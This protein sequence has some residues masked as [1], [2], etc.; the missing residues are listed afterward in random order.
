MIFDPSAALLQAHPS[1]NVGIQSFNAFDLGIQQPLGL[2][3]LGPVNQNK[4]W[5]AQQLYGPMAQQNVAAYNYAQQH[6]QSFTPPASNG[7]VS[8][9]YLGNFGL[10]RDDDVGDASSV[11][12]G[13][14]PDMTQF[15]IM[16]QAQRTRSASTISSLHS[17]NTNVKGS[18][19]PP[20]SAPAT[21]T[22]YAEANAAG[23]VFAAAYRNFPMEAARVPGGGNTFHAAMGLFM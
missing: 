15:P 4:Q 7:P 23:D 10:V 18:G 2:S 20:S 12:S 14:L 13:S 6:Q 1:Q 8:A 16:P 11:S 5:N 22:T 3:G 21:A 17:L 19:T 9:H